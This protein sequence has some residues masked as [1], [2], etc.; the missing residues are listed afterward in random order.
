MSRL[1]QFADDGGRCDPEAGAAERDVTRDKRRSAILNAGGTARHQ[2]TTHV[3][4]D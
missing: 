2:A 1:T 4:G 3:N